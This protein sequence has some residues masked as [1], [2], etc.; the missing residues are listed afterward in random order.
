MKAA[1]RGV[2]RAV[3]RVAV[4]AVLRAA[5]AVA[6][7]ARDAAWWTRVRWFRLAIAAFTLAATLVEWSVIPPVY[8]LNF[9]FSGLS[10]VGILTS[11]FLPRASGWLIIATVVGRLFVLD[12]SGPNPLWAAYLALAII[13]YDS[14]IPVAVAALLV[15]TASECVPV[16]LNAFNALSATWIGMIN[17]VGMF[18]L[19]SMAGMSFRWRRQR[20]EMRERAVALERRQWEADTLRRN[21]LLASRIHDSASGGLSTIALI[22]QRR[23]RRLPDAD[24]DVDDGTD[25]DADAARTTEPDRRAEREDWRFVNERAL[26]VLDEIHR[27]ID[28]LERP[29]RSGGSSDGGSDDGGV[30]GV[31]AG[32]PSVWRDDAVADGGGDAGNTADLDD[33]GE[34]AYGG[35]TS[36]WRIIDAAIRDAE[37]NLAHLGFRGAIASHGGLPDDCAIGPVRAAANLIGEIAA[38]IIRHMDPS[39]GEYRCVVT[40]GSDAI[41]VMETNPIGKSRASR[42]TGTGAQSSGPRATDSSSTRSARHGPRPHGSG[43]AMHRR[44]IEAW[45]GELNASAEDGDWVIY[46]RIPLAADE[47]PASAQ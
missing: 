8:P 7:G 15:V 4:V 23:L 18:T 2:V 34:R 25:A 44:I 47:A 16:A 27:V 20:D 32:A 41:A 6:R 3:V 35:D 10:V 37:T 36:G 19:A 12:L 43:L 22:A 14:A 40:M 29:G 28:L 5:H 1:I 17:Y 42:Q 33:A 13:G 24:D 26:A 31:A 46:A 45:G 30:P 21:T 39:A 38:N 11:P 9:L